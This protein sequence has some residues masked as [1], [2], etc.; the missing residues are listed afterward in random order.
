MGRLKGHLQLF[1]G[2]A[3]TGVEPSDASEELSRG[4]RPMIILLRF[5]SLL[6][7]FALQG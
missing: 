2:T 4:T 1:A 5:G 6:A 7:G 3:R